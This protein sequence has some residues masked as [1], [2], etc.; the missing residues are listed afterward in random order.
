M[1]GYQ[2]ENQISPSSPTSTRNFFWTGIE[3]AVVN[4]ITPI[5]PK[6]AHKMLRTYRCMCTSESFQSS[7]AINYDRFFPHPLQFVVC[8]LTVNG[9]LLSCIKIIMTLLEI[10]VSGNIVRRQRRTRCFYV[11]RITAMG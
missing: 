7:A 1:F 8:C 2:Y 3:A 10:I 5:V 9:Q 6:Y 4:R 11:V